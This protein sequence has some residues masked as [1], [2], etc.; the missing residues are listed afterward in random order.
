MTKQIEVV[1]NTTGE[2]LESYKI[3]TYNQIAFLMNSI[4]K[5]YLINRIETS[6]DIK[7]VWV[8]D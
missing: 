7:I 5:Y 1:S 6:D 3:D 2:V 8:Q 4:R